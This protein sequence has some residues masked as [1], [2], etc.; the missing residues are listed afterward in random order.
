MENTERSNW[1]WLRRDHLA[2]AFGCS[3]TF[4]ARFAIFISPLPMLHN[5]AHQSKSTVLE[6]KTVMCTFSALISHIVDFC[7]LTCFVFDF[8]GARDRP[9]TANK[10]HAFMPSCL[11]IREIYTNQRC[12]IVN[13]EE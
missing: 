3:I 2:S 6:L 12:R 1:K 5:T 11:A 8:L 10:L 7:S 4:H 9:L 13:T